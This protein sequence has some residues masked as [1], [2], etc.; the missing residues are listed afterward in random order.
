MSNCIITKTAKGLLRTV[1]MGNAHGEYTCCHQS[2]N[3]QPAY[4]FGGNLLHLQHRNVSTGRAGK[5][6]FRNVEIQCSLDER[7]NLTW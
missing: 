5:N 6:R 4:L 3:S 2:E 7:R 1:L